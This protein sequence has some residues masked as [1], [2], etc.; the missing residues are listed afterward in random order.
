[1][2]GILSGRQTPGGWR[3]Q[4]RRRGLVY[5][6]KLDQPHIN[7]RESLTVWFRR[8]LLGARWQEGGGVPV[9]GEEAR[10]ISIHRFGGIRGFCAAPVD[11]G[12]EGRLHTARSG[13][14]YA[15]H[16]ALQARISGECSLRGAEGG[17]REARPDHIG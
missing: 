2:P 7:S 15:D 11:L 8:L 13:Y 3:V 17:P 14:P 12:R 6:A 10:G 16:C 9:V 4:R 5:R 1:M